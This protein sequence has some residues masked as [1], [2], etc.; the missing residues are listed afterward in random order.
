[1]AQ[2]AEDTRETTLSEYLAACPAF[3][4]AKFET[5]P[6]LMSNGLISN[7]ARR[8]CPHRLEPWDNFLEEQRAI[9]RTLLSSFPADTR[10][11]MNRAYLRSRGEV[12]HRRRLTTAEAL[13]QILLDFVAEPVTAIV[14]RFRDVDDITSAFN[15]GAGIAFKTRPHTLA[16][17][18]RGAAPARPKSP[19]DT[20]FRPDHIYAYRRNSS[21]SNEKTMA[22]II[23]YRSPQNLTPPH[24]RLGLRPMDVHEEVAKRNSIPPEKEQEAYFQYHADRLAAS[25]LTQAF[26]YMIQA[27]LTYGC[28][29]TGETFVFLKINWTH[30]I[31]LLY[32][33]AEPA[34]EVEEHRE[35]ALCCTAVSQVLAFTMLALHSASQ[36]A[37]GQDE[38]QR[39]INRLKIWEADSMHQSPSDTGR[40]PLSTSSAH[41]PRTYKGVDRS[42][43]PFVSPNAAVGKRKAPV[44]HQ[45]G[46]RTGPGA[47]AVSPDSDRDYAEPEIPSTPTPPAGSTPTGQVLAQRR[48]G[49][50][51]DAGGSTE[52]RQYCTQKCLL[53]LTTRNVLDEACP[54]VYLHRRTD[55]EFRRHPVDHKTWLS[56]LRKQLAQT[57]DDG[58]VPLGQ[59]SAWGIVFQVTLLEYGYTFI[60]K[61][62]TTRFV[63]D[64][65]HEGEVYEHLQPLQGVH[66]PVFLGGVNLRELGRTYYYDTD[67][68]LIYMN[69]LSWAGRNRVDKVEKV[70]S[71]TGVFRALQALFACRVAHNGERVPNILWN[72][73]T[74]KAMVINFEQA[75]I[76]EWS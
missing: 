72:E 53:G 55:Q 13:E 29:T 74:E 63:P 75:T 32:H 44:G 12:I 34:L 57:L 36:P 48:G 3:V 65:S 27:G 56:L 43:R 54:N 33:M 41:E 18:T 30:P 14:E 64:L 42:P 39:A 66:V 59:Q 20:K 26:D 45:Q 9:M 68:R 46:Y 69:L 7:P 51:G 38:R 49:D 11:F 4:F 31:T 6:A 37:H 15:I 40:A 24:L 23:E 52:T 35:N 50:S 67:V 19:D 61:A 5:N 2:A 58:V 70:K 17:A 25:A 62:T 10:T 76:L 60:G 8:R 47:R 16:E 28:V 73:E 1:M 21:D 71:K 22:F